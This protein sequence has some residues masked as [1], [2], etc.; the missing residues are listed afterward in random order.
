MVERN[1]ASGVR[2][3]ECLVIRIERVALPA[4]LR[5]IAH[6][7]PN[8][9]LVI[10]VSD[11]LDAQRQRAA[12]LQALRASRRT[13][14]R[15]GLPPIGLV[16]LT[17]LRRWARYAAAALRAHPAG[18]AAATTVVVAGAAASGIFLGAAPHRHDLASARPPAASINLPLQE[19]RQQHAPV[20]APPGPQQAGAISPGSPGAPAR[21]SQPGAASPAPGQ[22]PSAAAPAPSPS[23]PPGSP[24]GP[25]PTPTSAPS[26]G[27]Q[28]SCVIILK[29]RVCLSLISLSVAA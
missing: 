8:G 19:R 12:V 5:A 23:S 11:G 27:H 17:P 15:A 24:P 3:A 29:V 28:E 2:A 25:S 9:D 10:Y 26:G 21:P 1:S 14:W 22:Q 20:S 6:R 13:G 16:L 4:G 7:D 18:W